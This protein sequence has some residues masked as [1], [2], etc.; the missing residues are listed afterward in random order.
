MHP[1]KALGLMS[2]TS[3]DGVDVALVETDGAAIAGLGPTGFRPYTEK[4]RDLLRKA[5]DDARSLTDRAARP[6]ALRVA[7]ELVTAAHL[8]AVLAFSS[9]HRLALSEIAV[10]G[11]HGQTVLHRPR[12]KLTVQLGHGADLALRLGVPV[13]YD[14]RAA[15][16]AAGGEGAPM[17]PAY[18]RALART[19]DLPQPLAIV[20]VGGVA[21][22]TYLDGNADPIAFDTGPGNAP[23]DEVARERT[24]DSRDHDGR[25]AALGNVDEE[26]VARVLAD[27]Y[28]RARAPKSLDRA[29]FARLPLDHLSNEDAAATATAVVAASIALARQQLPK[30]PTHWIVAGGG[31][32]N[33]AL[34]SML[35]DRLAARVMRAGDVGWS[36]D[37]LEAQ[38]FAFL[39]VRSLRGLPLT[40]PSTT[41]VPK[42]MTG[43]VLAE[44]RPLGRKKEK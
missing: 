6:G 3:F 33:S 30:P 19:L 20:N 12:D 24:G 15:D 27:P 2:G 26:T 25:L 22:I 32:H 9:D 41:G 31:A 40:F 38:A 23:I 34:I 42:P 29:T 1:L 37:A 35:R 14:F 13:V 10:V 44:P 8:E 16:V 11:F 17:V 28:F 4:E 21:N 36:V 7:E 18:H 5:M 43:G 39:A